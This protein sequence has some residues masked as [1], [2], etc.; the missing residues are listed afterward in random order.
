MVTRDTAWPA[1]TP[2]WVDLGV[3]DIARARAFY[4]ALF[5]W[6]IPA[7]PPEAGGYSIGEVNGGQ[8]AGIGPKMGPAGMPT[9]WTTYLATDDADETAER[10]AAADGHLIVE[11]FDV[12]DAGRMAMAS[13]PGGA[14]FGIWQAG[15]HIGAQLANTPGALIWNENMSRSFDGN[16]AFYRAVF[17][18]TYSD[19][20][21]GDF[22]YATIDLD[23]RT[24]GG[25]GEIGAGQPPEAPAHWSA[26]FAVDDTDAAAAKVTQLGGSVIAP[27]LD[28]PY[29]RMAVVS[30]DQGGVFSVMA[31]T[32]DG[33]A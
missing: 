22:R 31:A 33:Q 12:M 6:Q 4:S 5:G 17:G 25:I 19:I 10:I 9:V 8:V 27:P 30:D 20:A 2:C 14:V 18:Y 13:D 7:G 1:G 26:Y 21:A 32:P 24:V 28:T 23:G 15:A 11:P 29:G 3:D 16:K